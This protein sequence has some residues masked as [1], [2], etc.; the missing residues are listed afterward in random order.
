MSGT[1]LGRD[2]RAGD[3]IWRSGSRDEGLQLGS[4]SLS[5]VPQSKG[6]EKDIPTK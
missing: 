5:G 4:V 3:W 6:M 1:D 2:S